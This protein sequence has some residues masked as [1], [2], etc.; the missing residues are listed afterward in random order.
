[1]KNDNLLFEPQREKAGSQTFSKYSYQYHWALCR[2]LKEHDGKKEYAVFVELHEDVVV[3]N[4]LNI[5]NAEFEFSQVKTNQTK[6]TKDN[7]VKLKNDSS[8]LG[9]LIGS[10]I[11]KR[12]TERIKDI[13]LV[14][15]SGFTA[16]DFQ[17]KGISLNKICMS[18]IPDKTINNL[19]DKISKELNI[20]YFPI[21]LYFITSDIPDI[22]FQEFTLGKITSLVSKLF[23]TS[24]T[25]AENIYRPLIDELYRKGM[26]T[27]DFKEWDEVLKNKALTSITVNKIIHQFTERKEDKLV[28]AQLVDILEELELKTMVKSKWN[29]SFKRYYLQRIANKTL[30]QMEI[31]DAIQSQLNNCN[32]E[33][34]ILIGL[35]KDN[36]SMSVIK[37]FQDDIDIKTAI[38]CEYILGELSNE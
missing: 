38:I 1:M 14:A 9:K 21:N 2:V 15:S 35:V 3:S 22:G 27:I 37:N 12:Y 10:T 6:F 20:N 25:Q 31:K 32:E 16:K 11:Q 17:E 26:V 18:D 23:P 7:I 4:S 29:K 33:I 28:Y 8:V 19:I 13:N 34:Q 30:V 36:L 24:L 5:N